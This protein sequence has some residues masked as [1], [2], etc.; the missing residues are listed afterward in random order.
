MRLVKPIT[1]QKK[2]FALLN[3][4]FF[5]VNPKFATALRI[6]KMIPMVLPEYR[7][8]VILLLFYEL[9]IALKD[10]K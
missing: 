8:E 1:K 7:K 9:K 6:A 10:S 3:R 2:I 4:G 5:M